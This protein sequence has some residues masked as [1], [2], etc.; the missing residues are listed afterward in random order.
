MLNACRALACPPGCSFKLP[1]PGDGGGSLW[2]Y[3][4]TACLFHE[5][6]AV[7]TDI[8]G[9]PLDLNRPDSTFMSHRGVLYATDEPLARR[10]RSA[11]SGRP[12]R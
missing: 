4:A 11:F 2:D 1:R 8:H 7:A 6:G 5:A 9:D 12:T 10:L 3:A